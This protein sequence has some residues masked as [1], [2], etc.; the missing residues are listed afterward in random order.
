MLPKKRGPLLPSP[1]FETR[2]IHRIQCTQIKDHHSHPEVA[3]FEDAPQL[4]TGD[5]KA[6][7]LRGRRHIADVEDFM[8]SNS[9]IGVILYQIYDCEVYHKEME[10]RFRPLEKPDDPITKSL[11]PYFFRLDE[12]GIP[13]TSHKQA[14][15]IPS[16]HLRDVIAL[17]TDLSP[18]IIIE[19]HDP[20]F[21]RELISRVYHLR[22]IQT[23]STILEKI[24]KK[25]FEVAV[26]FVEFMER[27]F[28]HEYDEA[29]SLFSKGLMTRF[30]LPKLFAAKEIL[31]TREQGQ[32]LAYVLDESPEDS[33]LLSCWT[34]RFDGRFWKYRTTFD[35]KLHDV[36]DGTID[37]TTL[38][39]FP[40]KY[41]TPDVQSLIANRGRQFWSV[42][43]RSY[44]SYASNEKQKDW[45]NIQL[46][47]M[48]DMITYREL[49]PE[50]DPTEEREYLSDE[51]TEAEDPPDEN[52]LLLLP[53]TVHGFGFQDKKWRLLL[54]SHIDEIRWNEQAFDHLVLHSTK[55]ELIRALVK[56]HDATNESTDVIE[57]KGNGLILLLHGGPGTGKTL[58]AESVAELTHRPLYRVTCGDVGTN[59]D[60]VEEY[61]E[62][63]LHLG[64]LWRCVVLLDEADVFLEERTHQDLRRNALVSVFLRVIE[65][66]D[67]ILV[68]TSNRIGTFDEAFKSRVQLIVHYPKLK[69][70]D[71]WRIWS[72]FFNNIR[73]T[74]VGM[75]IEELEERIGDLSDNELNGREIRNTI[76]TA[77]LLAQF[78]EEHLRY[79]HLTK[80]ISVS[81]EFRQYLRDRFGHDDEELVQQRQIR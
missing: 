24:G 13:A 69:K 66:Y 12:D 16:D 34:W 18:E 11:L 14:M 78:K 37:I 20:E 71:R 4:F 68:L 70:E 65:Y 6:S 22:A 35:I 46:R 57:G 3:Y 5:S 29:D 79:E 72:K 38:S 47:Y 60:D 25:S 28:R 49:H 52:F 39:I 7:A 74:G 33:S 73:N 44:V 50:K 75:N 30:H 76:Q 32:P 59:A 41:A 45:Q 53:A 48:V 63:V 43:H 77:T 15:H 51:S 31:V 21:M 1:I 61:L 10:P 9:H 80:V 42:R 56:K 54:V 81:E 27:I 55:K 23:D 64:K 62:S 19:L 58:T 17:L 36:Q 26:C 67:G 40:L 8:D 2:T